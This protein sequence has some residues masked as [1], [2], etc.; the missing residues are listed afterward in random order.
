M[1][2]KNGK[3]VTGED[4]V[5]AD[6]SISDGKIVYIGKTGKGDT[7][8]VFDAR[9]L[10][11]FPG[12]IDP[13]VHFRDPGF[14]NKEDFESG[15]RGAAAGGTTTVFD[16][17]NTNPVV[18]SG[19]IL[20]E[21]RVQVQSRA[22]VDYGLIAAASHENVAEMGALATAGAIAFKTY[23]VSPPREREKEYAGSFVTSAGELYESMQAVAKTG[24]VH[25]VHAES[26]SLIST[27]TE[28]LKI[29]GR[30]D[31]LAHFDSRPNFTEEEAV[32][33]SLL[34]AEILR[35]RL[36]LVHLSTTEASQLLARAKE[37]G[38]DVTAETC[39]QY[40]VF[41]K[42]VLKQ[43]GP[44]GKFNPP[45]RSEKD[46]MEM[47][48][49]MSAGL[50]DMVSTDHAPHLK[51]DKQVGRDD[52]FR[53][54]SGTSGVETR[55]PLLL[56]MVHQGKLSLA[57]IPRITSESAARRFGLYPTKG[58]LRVGSDADIALVDF[59]EAWTIR[60]QELQ[61][62]SRETVL[63]DGMAVRGKVKA[64]I[65]RGMLVYEE[66]KG[67]A[68]AGTGKFVRPLNSPNSG[69]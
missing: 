13:H 28:N 43:R 56:E 51:E 52:I 20:Q 35:A 48:R 67:F 61:T 3:I 50:I 7:A 22:I 1:I 31:P 68:K 21:K 30:K 54:P 5:E 6:I 58:A 33:Q 17:P 45:A 40:M 9:G 57:D 59:N 15:T 16:M 26:D 29:E 24:V 41:T 49:A 37:R 18:R 62:K 10:L 47:T 42:E 23:M 32:F 2:I 4:L 69:K 8:K 14:T 65:L 25:C 55:L 46:R 44:N 27:L 11:V 64:T 34:L 66:G 53:A 63:Y 12:L 39:P 38:V 36:H 19:R 60:G